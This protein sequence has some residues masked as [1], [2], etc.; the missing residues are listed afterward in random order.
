MELWDVYDRNGRFTGRTKPK[1]APFAP[2]EYHLAAEVWIVNS[3]GELLIQ[4]RAASCEI[5]PGIWALTAGRM[6]AGEDSRT[7]CLRELREE[8]GVCCEPGDLHLLRRIFRTEVIWDLYVL[9]RDLDL[10][11]LTLQPEEVAEARWVT[12]RA[13]RQGMEDGSLFV[14]PEM[15][16]VLEQVLQL[17]GQIQK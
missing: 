13:Y 4:R 2:G 11:R 9:C 17:A 5:L 14:Y 16:E 6:T 3:A 10:A 7:G 1:N 8:L 15:E 12:P